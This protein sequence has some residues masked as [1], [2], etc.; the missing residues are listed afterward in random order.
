MQ[1]IAN[2][3]TPVRFRPEPPLCSTPV[4]VGETIQCPRNDKSPPQHKKP[5]VLVS[6][7]PFEPLKNKR[8]DKQVK[9]EQG[10][11]AKDP[12]E[13]KRGWFELLN[14]INRLVPFIQNVS[15][16]AC[17]ESR[18]RRDVSTAACRLMTATR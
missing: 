15:P 2:P 6:S 8:L 13:K 10:E 1:R 12:D 11:K 17:C 3:S 5:V 16:A 4:E 14:H 18:I 9:R 7:I